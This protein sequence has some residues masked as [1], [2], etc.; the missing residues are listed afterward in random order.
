MQF[1]KIVR[2]ILK[3][4][5]PNICLKIIL[6]FRHKHYANLVH[7]V[8]EECNHQ[9]YFL[10]TIFNSKYLCDHGMHCLKSIEKFLAMSCITFVHL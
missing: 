9:Y 6:N 1:I 4:F 7:G 10:L 2:P 3:I 8:N 5:F